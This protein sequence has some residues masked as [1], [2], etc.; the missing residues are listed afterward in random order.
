M[1]LKFMKK[2]AKSAIVEE[3]SVSESVV[4]SLSVS[5]DV[6]HTEA[7]LEVVPS[8]EEVSVSI[9]PHILEVVPVVATSSENVPLQLYL[10][11]IKSRQQAYDL[12]YLFYFFVDCSSAQD[13][14][15]QV[16]KRVPYFNKLFEVHSNSQEIDSDFIDKLERLKVDN[17]VQDFVR[18]YFECCGTILY[19]DKLHAYFPLNPSSMITELIPKSF[20]I[21]S[22]VPVYKGDNALE[23]LSHLYDNT[24][25]DLRSEDMFEIY[26]RFA[27]FCDDTKVPVLKYKK[28]HENARIFKKRASDEGYDVALVAVNKKMSDCSVRFDTGLQ[29]E[30]PSGY[31]LEVVPRS[32]LFKE[33]GAVLANNVGIIDRPYRGNLLVQLTQVDENI[34]DFP[35]DQLKL[36]HVAVQVLLKKSHHFTL[37]PV[38]NFDNE[39]NR[40]AG[41]FGSTN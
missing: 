39:T 35:L 13:G 40:G 2:P 20:V 1:D 31:Y 38:E 21:E 28:L 5:D 10:N 24:H 3:K 37:N 23:F 32:S 16:N 22:S 34:V 17:Y 29:F 14:V 27:N 9:K 33:T 6:V 8:S 15:Y 25:P 7:S 4:D 11:G 19:K 36:P 26:S 12:G 41:G 18:G 30:I